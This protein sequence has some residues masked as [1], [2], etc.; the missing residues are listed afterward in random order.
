MERKK[1]EEAKSGNRHIRVLGMSRRLTSICNSLANRVNDSTLAS[2]TLSLQLPI[3]TNLTPFSRHSGWSLKRIPSAR[4]CLAWS[5][6]GR[7]CA[8]LIK[9]RDSCLLSR[10][11]GR[12]GEVSHGGKTVRFL[13][14]LLSPFSVGLSVFLTCVTG[15]LGS[16]FNRYAADVPCPK[17]S[18]RVICPDVQ[19]ELVM[20]S[21]ANKRETAYARVRRW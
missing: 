14:I 12:K 15:D 10:G 16:I 20:I 13:S 4:S 18:K 1:I 21:S 3:K 2:S 5:F 19:E 8:R 11:R 6:S 7:N 17:V 9:V